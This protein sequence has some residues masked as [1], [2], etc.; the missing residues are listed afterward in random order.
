MKF[1]I[2]TRPVESAGTSGIVLLR[3]QDTNGDTS[4]PHPPKSLQAC[5]DAWARASDFGAQAGQIAVFPS[6]DGPKSK[7]ILLLGLGRHTDSPA[8]RFRALST[9]GRKLHNL[10]WSS[11]AIDLSN[12]RHDESMHRL[13]ATAIH[14]GA[15][16]FRVFKPARRVRKDIV[17][18][19]L[20]GLGTGA[21]AKR[22]EAA[23]TEGAT[24]GTTLTDIRS[25]ANLPGNCATP[26]AI[27]ASCKHIA[28]R[29]G[30]RYKALGQA[31]LARENCNA[32]LAVGQGSF[33]EPQLVM[34][35]HPGRNPKAAPIVLIGKTITFDSGGISIKPAKSM[36]WMKYDKSGGMAVLAAMAAIA[37]LKLPHRVIGI[38]VAAEN[39]PGGRATRPGDIVR[40]R[41]GTSIEIINTDAE[42]RLVL[43]DAISLAQDLKPKFMIDLATLTG[44]AVTALGSVM[45]AVMGNS[46]SLVD[47]LMAAGTRCGELLWPLPLH[48]AYRDMLNSPFADIRNTGDGTAGAIAGG[49]FLKEFVNP[50]LP[51][52][53]IDLTHA[54]EERDQSHSAAGAN[55]FGARLLVEWLKNLK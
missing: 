25:I 49:M 12:V 18:V 53:H 24:L 44:A 5:A 11:V 10:G 2:S 38:L 21:E 4:R 43:A 19:T 8:Q 13:L 40:A 33:N 29:A 9:L 41:S 42:G 52:A 15:Y 16:E 55:L 27:A 37:R 20:H 36:E 34:L 17:T 3:W 14:V 31:A 51:W 23:I 22:F 28:M 54:W 46:Q 39:M 47:G 26:A 32:L 6:W 7:T 30:L 50:A 48:P 35:E 45:S 1:S